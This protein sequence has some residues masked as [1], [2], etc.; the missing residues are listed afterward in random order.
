MRRLGHAPY[1]AEIWAYMW[2]SLVFIALGTSAYGATTAL[3]DLKI[4]PHQQ[5]EPF[6]IIVTLLSWVW[7]YRIYQ[8]KGRG[9]RIIAEYDKR[10][11]RLYLGLGLLFTAIPILAPVATILILR[12]VI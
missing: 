8:K 3:L 4:V 9:S 5:A 11:T 2:I 1:M 7:T 12:V 6:L 10:N